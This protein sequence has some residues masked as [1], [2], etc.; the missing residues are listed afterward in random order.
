MLRVLDRAG[1][2]VA[3][4]GMLPTLLGLSCGRGRGL[5]VLRGMWVKGDTRMLVLLGDRGIH[6][7]GLLTILGSRGGDQIGLSMSSG[8]HPSSSLHNGTEDMLSL[9]LVVGHLL[10]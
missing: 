6:G 5:W 9:R 2:G 8:D 4:A 10:H 3:C 1:S 7:V